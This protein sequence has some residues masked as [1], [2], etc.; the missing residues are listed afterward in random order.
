MMLKYILKHIEFEMPEA[1]KKLT[2]LEYLDFIFI[3][4]GFWNSSL[5]IPLFY[6]QSKIS[7]QKNGYLPFR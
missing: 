5:Q 6:S 2:L 7:P 3:Y 1:N 4:Q